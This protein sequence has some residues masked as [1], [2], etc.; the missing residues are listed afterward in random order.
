[1]DI[2]NIQ[3]VVSLRPPSSSEYVSATLKS[4]RRICVATSEGMVQEYKIEDGQVVR[5]L[6]VCLSIEE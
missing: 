1:M 6:D 4:D 5:S 3:L 2:N